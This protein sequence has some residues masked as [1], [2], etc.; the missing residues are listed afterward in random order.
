MRPSANSYVSV[1]IPTFR[2]S[3]RLLETLRIL[4]TC[5]PPP[6]EVLV[7]IDAGDEETEHA[8]RANAPYV[9]LRTAETMQG[10]GGSRNWL[11]GA[12]KYPIVVS[13]DDDSYPVD[14]DFFGSV[15]ATFAAHPDAGVIAM[16]IVNDGEAMPPR[17]QTSQDVA[18]F[19]GGGCAYRQS[20][21]LSTSGYIPLHPAY[22]MEE[23][24]IALQIMDRGW[25]IVLCRDLRIRHASNRAN[26]THP[27]VVAAHVRNTALL[28][29]LRYPVRLF[30][31]GVGQL[32][33]RCLYSVRR[34]HLFGTLAGLAQTPGTLF[35][36]RALRQ[37]V[38]AKTVKAVRDL[39]RGM[40][41]TEV[42]D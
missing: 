15:L 21:F 6:G 38:A 1:V 29:Y 35:R 18:D 40:S 4:E 27:E 22:G 37:P 33:N 41:T 17:Q 32:A 8:L 16:Q 36:Y 9:R 30:P 19:G 11:I 3:A 42:A 26:Q 13:L 7:H 2:R 20:A 24:D 12:A 5:D 39:R 28:A 31:R 10:P 14:P 23:T 34:G 25:R